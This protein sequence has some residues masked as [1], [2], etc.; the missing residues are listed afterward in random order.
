MKEFI[1][2]IFNVCE[3]YAAQPMCPSDPDSEKTQQL[4]GFAHTYI[5]I[6]VEMLE[7]QIFSKYKHPCIANAMSTEFSIVHSRRTF[8]I[9]GLWLLSPLL[10]TWISLMRN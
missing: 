9:N 1:S 8:N 2:L 3:A 5:Y 7:L 4:N 6:Y 10:G